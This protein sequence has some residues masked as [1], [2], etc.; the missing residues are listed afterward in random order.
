MTN[1]ETIYALGLDEVLFGDENGN[2]REP[3]PEER[4]ALAA[5]ASSS[6]VNASDDKT[7]FWVSLFAL[8]RS[9]R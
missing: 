9:S 2:F 6:V 1:L 4:E 7:N 5:F 8:F 3:T